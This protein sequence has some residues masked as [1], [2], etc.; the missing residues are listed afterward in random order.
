MKQGL[1]IFN[2]IVYNGKN[3]KEIE[4]ELN[5]ACVE[6]DGE[7]IVDSAGELT[8]QKGDCFMRV[9]GWICVIPQIDFKK[10]FRGDIKG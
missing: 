10:I 2:Y 1:F 8:V 7:L 6:E 5:L 9:P 4:N 3:A